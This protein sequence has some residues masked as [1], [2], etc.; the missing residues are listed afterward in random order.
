MT[1]IKDF[2]DWF[3]RLLN[4]SVRH[5]E[6]GLQYPLG[7]CCYRDVLRDKKVKEALKDAW[8]RIIIRGEGED[9]G[10]K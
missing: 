10:E 1:D 3:N 2:N 5:S 4:S 8:D 7:S 9:R 6:Y